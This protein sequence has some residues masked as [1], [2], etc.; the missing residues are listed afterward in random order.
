MI[1]MAV[2]PGDM[3]MDEAAQEE[4]SGVREDYFGK[5]LPLVGARHFLRA[6]IKCSNK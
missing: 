4:Q 6:S 1:A 2:V 3:A 5:Y